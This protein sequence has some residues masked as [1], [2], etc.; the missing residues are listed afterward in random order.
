M[1]ARISLVILIGISLGTSAQAQSRLSQRPTV[2]SRGAWELQGAFGAGYQEGADP[3]PTQEATP[4]L[5]LRLRAGVTDDLTFVFPAGL[6]GRVV[7]RPGIDLMLGAFVDGFGNAPRGTLMSFQL[8]AS[9]FHRLSPS[10]SLHLAARF[11]PTW[12]LEAGDTNSLVMALTS[13]IVTDVSPAV[14]MTL[15]AEGGYG[16]GFPIDDGGGVWAVGGWGF[17]S[18]RDLPFVSWN[19]AKALDFIAAWEV[20]RDQALFQ[21]TRSAVV[22]V[23]AAAGVE[24]RFGRD[25]NAYDAEWRRAQSSSERKS[26]TNSSAPLGICDSP[27][28]RSS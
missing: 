28:G 12:I 13:A 4:A 18:G 16:T 11:T 2:A 14:T 5:I 26:R 19:I 6:V 25:N 9:T 21:N 24:W 10:T 23:R 17:G 22:E 27:C 15:S 3:R 1:P 7:E 8:F 20:R